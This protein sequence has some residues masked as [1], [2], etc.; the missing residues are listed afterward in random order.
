MGAGGVCIRALST[1]GRPEDLPESRF[2][3]EV[4]TS[5]AWMAFAI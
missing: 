5:A 3:L 1:A 4:S 2:A